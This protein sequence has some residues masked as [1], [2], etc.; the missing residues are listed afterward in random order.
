MKLTK[1]NLGVASLVLVDWVGQYLGYHF[2][3]GVVNMGVTF[4]MF[5]GISFWIILVFWAYLVIKRD[6]RFEKLVWGG[7]GNL[8][9]R[10]L[11]GGVWD[12]IPYYF[13]WGNLSDLIITV[14]VFSYIL[15]TNGD[16]DSLRG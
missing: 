4:G 8:V 3:F 5:Q 13:F 16:R 1:K 11:F 15:G 14:G 6:E 2:G 9:P 7:L 10:V 12:Y